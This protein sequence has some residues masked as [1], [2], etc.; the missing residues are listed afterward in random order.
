MMKTVAIQPSIFIS[1]GAP[2]ILL[3]EQEAVKAL[4]EIAAWLP[5]PRAI[6]IVS[7]HWIDDPIGI[8]TG[9]DLSTLHDFGGFP[10]PLY[11]MEYPAKG[12]DELSSDITRHLRKNGLTYRLVEQRGLDH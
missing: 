3:S 2:D 11:E 9:G 5:V 12:D 6:V 7:A 1:H 8:T 4:R 10:E